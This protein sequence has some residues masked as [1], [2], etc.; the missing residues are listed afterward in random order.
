[1]TR[2]L[3]LSVES[4]EDLVHRMGDN[5]DFVC[6]LLLPLA[7]STTDELTEEE[8]DQLPIDL[9]YLPSDKQRESDRDIQQILLETLLLVGDRQKGTNMTSIDC[10]TF[11]SVQ[12]RRS[13]NTSV[14]N[15]SI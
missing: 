1:M 12:R 2:I 15:R 5:D 4:H 6:A 13:G 11:S 7:G 9:Q 8:N 10:S 14:R 3:F